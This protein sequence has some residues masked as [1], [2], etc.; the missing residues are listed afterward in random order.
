MD[1]IKEKIRQTK[2]G[3]RNPNHR[4]V[5]QTD[6]LTGEQIIFG[7]MQEGA[8]YHKV[9]NKAF[10]YKQIIKPYHNRYMFEDYKE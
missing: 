2:M 4:K 6:L 9:K 10:I 7:S 5:I 8:R 1:I 3:D